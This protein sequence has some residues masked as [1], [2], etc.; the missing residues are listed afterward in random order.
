MPKE[1]PA[2]ADE[3]AEP[4]VEQENPEPS[5]V[6]ISL[7]SL[8]FA[9]ALSEEAEDEKGEADQEVAPDKNKPDVVEKRQ[10]EYLTESE[11]ELIDLDDDDASY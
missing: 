8:P 9:M 7:P 5:I 3:M 1:E 6:E 11:E 2:I 10:V 4:S